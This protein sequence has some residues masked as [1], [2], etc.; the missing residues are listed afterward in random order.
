MPR[1]FIEGPSS[2]TQPMFSPDGRWLAYSS[3]AAGAFEVYVQSFPAGGARIQVSPRGGG[4]PRW[5]RSGKEL[6]YL[7]P[8]G[9]LM[10]V[11]VRSGDTIEFGT[12]AALFKFFSPRRG[13]P[14]QRPPYDVTA[15]GQR[16][17]ISSVPRRHDASIQVVLNWPALTATKASQ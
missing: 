6:F 1:A 11:P 12:P 2:E 17:I 15:D 3:N 4:S 9:T 5:S 16:F 8:D 7:A 13:S 14:T 10:A